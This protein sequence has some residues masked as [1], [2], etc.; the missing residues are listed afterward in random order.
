MKVKLAYLAVIALCFALVPTALGQWSSDPAKNLPLADQGNGNDQVQPKVKPLP[1]N[2]WY[3]SWF[4][5]SPPSIGYDVYLQRINPAGVEQFP[6][7]GVLIADLKNSST[8][9]YGLDIDTQGDA[10][11]AFLDTREGTNE[12]VTAAR[13]GPAGK[14]MWGLRGVQ[15]TND[16]SFHAAPKIAGTSD[17]YVVVA[18][19]SDSNVVVQKLDGNGNPL[20]GTGIVFSESGYNYSLADLHAADNGSVI[21]SW[22][23][24]QGFGS[25]RQLRANKLSATGTL[26]WGQQNVTI[27]DQGSLQFGAFPYFILDGS[28]GAVF[29]WYTSSPTLQGFAQHI[30]SDGS[31]AFPHNGSAASTNTVNVRVSA[32]ASY[33]AA[34]DETFLFWTEEDSNQVLNGVYAQK[35]ASTGGRA[36]GQ[37]GL[38]VVP[39]GSDSQIFVES[40]QVGSGALVFWVDQATFGSGTIQATRLNDKGQVVCAQFPVASTPAS[41]F[42]LVADVASSHLA[43][44]AWADNRI[45]NNAI[46][47]QNVNPN[48]SLGPRSPH[49]AFANQPANS[50]H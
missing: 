36:W 40:V 8:E 42:G 31:E 10:L 50:K 24:D 15:L 16:S 25:N 21:L 7:D 14:P 43:A 26:L 39:L 44:L 4:D 17:G 1:N 9:D 49:G 2:G 22:V 5:S 33:R 46:Y 6:H 23:R 3:V 12:Q 41:S 29:A 30:R 34:T 13:I 38:T 19:T 27:F 28:G 32:S 20:W 18:W 48:C 37:T 45:G 35:F 11:L 47:I